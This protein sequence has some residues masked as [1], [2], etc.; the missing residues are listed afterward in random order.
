MKRKLA[1][2][3]LCLL[4]VLTILPTAAL[5]EEATA[6]TTPDLSFDTTT[7]YGDPIS[8]DIIK[9]FDLVFVN[10][11]AEWCSP[12]VG[13]LPS[14]EKLHQ[15]YP[16]VLFLGVWIGDSLDNAKQTLS[17]AGVTYPVIEP[18]GTLWSYLSGMQCIPASF[19][20]NSDGMQ[21]GEDIYVGSNSYYGWKEIIEDLLPEEEPLPEEEFDGTIEWNPQDIQYKGNTPY[22]IFDAANFI[23]T[24]RF[25]V[26]DSGGN[27]VDPSNYDYEF[28]YN[29]MPGT[30]YL[31]VTMKGAYSGLLKGWF[32]IYLPASEWLTV[33]NVADGV[34]L[35]WAPVTGAAGYVIYRRAWSTTTNGWTSF[36]RWWN[37]TGTS[38]TDGTDNHDVYAGSRYQ[39]GVK[40]YFS[41]RYDPIAKEEIGGN[42]NENSG[43]YNLGVVSDLKTTVRITTRKLES[44]EGGDRQITLR[45]S[46][47]KVFSGYQVQIAT[48]ANF[49]NNLMQAKIDDWK[50]GAKTFKNLP[51]GTVYYARVRSYHIFEGMTYYG[52]WSNVLSVKI[53]S[54]QTVEP[55]PTVYRALLIGQNNYNDS[56]LRGCINDMNAIAGSLKGLANSFKTTT[57]EDA[58]RA[59]ILNGIETVFAGATDDD[60]SLFHYSGHGVYYSTDTSDPYFQKFQGALCTIDGNYIYLSELADALSK[61][62]GKVIV[63]LDSCHSGAA[64]GRSTESELDAFNAAAIEAFMNASHGDD[65]AK[66]Q[67]FNN[68]KFIV[69]TA[70][71]YTQSSYDGRFDGSGY[72][73]GAFSAAFVKGL[74]CKYP[75]GAF[76]GSMPADTNGDRNLTLGE[77]FQYTSDTAYN[78]TG[79]QRAQCYGTDSEVLFMR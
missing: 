36:E 45:W 49:K 11:W 43:N 5:A 64:I 68:S 34:L 15:E 79:S 2:L 30:A 8:S 12:C 58:S 22:R 27:A 63:I 72:D 1:A 59:Q 10:F 53:G 4:M 35:N 61:V 6:R 46:R 31:F 37:V 13:E 7:I 55:S 39:Y 21:V 47:S 50:T 66:W 16:N 48:D 62:K 71:S 44:V 28:R 41:R 78:W 14:L 19:F 74:G 75:D 69:I 33:E 57:I 60:V 24:P 23:C 54:N 38:W 76:T 3:I 73:Q 56:P 9:N 26:K 20:F 32:K 42:V 77:I 51:N 18:S 17:D 40:A 70:A 52:Q 25:T 65:G 29:N 67:D